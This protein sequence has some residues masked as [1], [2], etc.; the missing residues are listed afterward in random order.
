MW[1][2][3]YAELKADRPLPHDYLTH[4]QTPDYDSSLPFAQSRAPNIDRCATRIWPWPLTLTLTLT[5]DLWPWP[6]SKV[7]VMSKQDF[8]HLTLTFDLDLQSQPSPGQG[9]PLR[10]ISRSKVK[11][12]SRESAHWQ[13]DW[14]TDATNSIISL[15]SRSITKGGGL[16]S[17]TEEQKSCRV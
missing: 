14:R 12:F 4:R 11:L 10:Q 13:T 17:L 15:A 7:T 3:S 8:W 6:Q 5:R 9:R 2:P 16:N 1:S